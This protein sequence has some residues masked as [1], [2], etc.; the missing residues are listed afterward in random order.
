[1]WPGVLQTY[2]SVFSQPLARY[3]EPP[4]SSTFTRSAGQLLDAASAF[5]AALLIAPLAQ[6]AMPSPARPGRTGE[7]ERCHASWVLS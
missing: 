1:M 5:R 7:R 6:A 3:L 2:V 4:R